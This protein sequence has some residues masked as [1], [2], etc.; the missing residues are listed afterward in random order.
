MNADEAYFQEAERRGQAAKAQADPAAVKIRAA[1]CLACPHIITAP[2]K[3][4]GCG[5]SKC[6]ID[7]TPIRERIL[8]SG[9]PRGR[10]S[11]PSFTTLDFNLSDR[12][13][14]ACPGCYARENYGAGPDMDRTRATIRWFVEQSRGVETKVRRVN[15]YGGEPLLEWDDLREAVEWTA[16]AWPEFDFG[17]VVVTNVTLLTPDKIEWL[18]DH[19]V[20][21]SC[22]IDGNPEAEMLSRHAGA[23]VFENARALIAKQPASCRMTV[24]PATAPFVADSVAYLCEEIG[25]HTVNAIVADGVHWSVEDIW[26]FKHQITKL[27]DWWIARRRAGKNCGLYHIRNMI[28][29][30]QAG[31][32]RRSVCGAGTSRVAVDTQGNLWPCHRFCNLRSDP[33]YKLGTLAAG[34][35]NVP[36][37]DRL[38]NY[39]LAFENR[40]RC[41]TCP[42]VLGCHHFCLW[43]NMIEKTGRLLGPMSYTCAIWPH[44][45]REAMRAYAILTAE[46]LWK[47]KRK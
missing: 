6:S 45:W 3:C 25:F 7:G 33:A 32:R 46:K 39:D 10:F 11:G 1:I 31:Q 38:R 14:L 26:A 17:F 16:Q 13:N 20:R 37:F 47:V 23:E 2:A 41:A 18:T 29:R 22:S 27:T 42:A 36:L 44:Y 30:L 21:V 15:I 4:R 8:S 43:T 24:T 19:K 28:D 40:E 5:A 12:C 34:F 35:W 9:C